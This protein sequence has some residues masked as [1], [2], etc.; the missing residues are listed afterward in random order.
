MKGTPD[1]CHSLE[2]RQSNQPAGAA[3]EAILV[4]SKAASS[5]ETDASSLKIDAATEKIDFE[6]SVDKLPGSIGS[7]SEK[8]PT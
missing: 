8:T 6:A 5:L 4:P 3:G 1:P 2:L 7:D